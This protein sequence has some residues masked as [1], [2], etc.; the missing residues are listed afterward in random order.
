LSVGLF[1][2][3]YD[4]NTKIEAAMAQRQTRQ[5]V[6]GVKVSD[7]SLLSLLASHGTGCHA[8]ATGNYL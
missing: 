2:E 4:K 3:K 7:A 1:H 5:C 6:Q 8:M